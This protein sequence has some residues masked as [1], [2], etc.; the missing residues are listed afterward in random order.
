MQ[1]SERGYTMAEL[2]VIVGIIGILVAI[3]LPAWSNHRI[4]SAN[5]ACLTE[6][7]AYVITAI[8]ALH[9]GVDVPAPNPSR[10]T[11]INTAAAGTASAMGT[12]TASAA[13][14]GDAQVTCNLAVASGACSY[15]SPSGN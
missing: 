10:C 14:P 2:M 3:A 11:F 9:D 7:S 8:S 1:Q 4:R 13:T 5:G 15:T 12:I 6:T